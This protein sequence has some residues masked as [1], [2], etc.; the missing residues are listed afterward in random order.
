MVLFEKCDL[1]SFEEEGIDFSKTNLA[2]IASDS[3]GNGVVLWYVGGH[4]SNEIDDVGL[5]LTGDLGLDDAP[6]GICV[7]EGNFKWSPGPWEYPDDGDFYPVG[8]FRQPTPE[9]W[10]SIHKNECPWNP[11]EWFLKK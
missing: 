6:E 1:P 5:R 10:E 2:V 9:E 7:W 8:K 11:Q 3:R 4:I